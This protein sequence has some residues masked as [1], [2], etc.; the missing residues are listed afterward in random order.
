MTLDDLYRSW[1]DAVA[2]HRCA[3]E[4]KLAAYYATR[5]VWDSRAMWRFQVLFDCHIKQSDQSIEEWADYNLN[6]FSR[7]LTI[8]AVKRAKLYIV[9]R[10]TGIANAI[11]YK[12]ASD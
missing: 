8:I 9:A 6:E 12:L 5:S 2:E 1:E 3:F 7:P 10:D 4:K 11:L